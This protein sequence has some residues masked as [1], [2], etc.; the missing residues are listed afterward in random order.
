MQGLA[1]NVGAFGTAVAKE[2]EKLEEKLDGVADQ[3]LDKVKAAFKGNLLKGG[4]SSAEPEIQEIES[5]AGGSP[6][7]ALGGKRPSRGARRQLCARTPTPTPLRA[8]GPVRARSSL[9][10]LVLGLTGGVLRLLCTDQSTARPRVQHHGP[11]G[12]NVAQAATL[13]RVAA[14]MQ[15][16]MWQPQS[17]SCSSL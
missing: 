6:L 1:E 7:V 4:G 10:M 13:Q 11:R 9:I 17:D 16:A 5:P 12:T 3:V 14:D 2:Q 15:R 8:H